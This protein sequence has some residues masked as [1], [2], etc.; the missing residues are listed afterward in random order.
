M[1][2]QP[3][4]LSCFCAGEPSFLSPDR[5]PTE[6]LALRIELAAADR[7]TAAACLRTLAD[8]V[9]TKPGPAWDV[10]TGPSQAHAVNIPAAMRLDAAGGVPFFHQIADAWR[11]R[12]RSGLLPVGSP[13][14]S[15]RALASQLDVNPMTV[16]KAYSLLHREGLIARRRGSAYTVAARDL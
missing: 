5:M 14:P 1:R 10:A 12:I 7:R 9:A 6:P 2:R 3:A 13:L 8:L 16:S 11:L 15:T 4:G